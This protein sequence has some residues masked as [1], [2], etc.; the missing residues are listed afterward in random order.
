MGAIAQLGE[1][2]H[3]MQE[4]S[5]S[6]P[7]SSTIFLVAPSKSNCSTSKP[8]MSC[9]RTT[10]T[11]VLIIG[12]GIVGST[13]ALLLARNCAKNLKITLLDTR[14]LEPE[15]PAAGRSG[16]T[17]DTLL[18]YRTS[19]LNHASQ[20]LFAEAGIW[21]Q[22]LPHACPYQA[23]VVQDRQSEAQ[24]HLRAQDAQLEHLGHNIANC[25]IRTA[26]HQAITRDIAQTPTITFIQIQKID[27]I[28]SAGADH[29]SIQLTSSTGETE[30]YRCK[31]ILAA[32]GKNST[33][34]HRMG[35]STTQSPV[36]QTAVT[37][38]VSA[39]QPHHGTARQIFLQQGPVALL[40]MPQPQDYAL[41][42]STTPE[43]AEALIQLQ[44][45]AFQQKVNSCFQHQHIATIRA[46]HA[47]MARCA[48]PIMQSRANSYIH[49][50]FALLGDAAHSIHPLAGLGLNLG[51]ADVAAMQR[52]IKKYG[53]M[54][55]STSIPKLL[56][57]YQQARK[58]M[59]HAYLLACDLLNKL[60]LQQPWYS[61]FFRKA[62][63][64]MI[65]QS[66][67][68]KRQLITLATEPEQAHLTR[69]AS[70]LN[71]RI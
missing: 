23:M 20:R 33:T 35:I 53:A 64:Q 37:S 17:D 50:R 61:R 4:V 28:H 34:R 36:T 38:L 21:S 66:A 55:D 30:A 48:Y 58:N 54:L 43:Q 11:D 63:I 39:T 22:L 41:I 67:A 8:D 27:A 70:Y 7:L 56:Q 15:Q 9:A 40:P 69:L 65:Q 68:L 46:D 52:V 49:T 45:E 14:A 13:M 1:R 12:A 57:D 10:D 59:N 29:S 60:F 2:L 71:N 51:L 3:G 26:L 32:D 24:L 62:G 16:S 42:W 19:T 47:N 18:D 44:P 5:G 6:I 31:L 25:H